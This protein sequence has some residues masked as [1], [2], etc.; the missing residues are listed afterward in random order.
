MVQLQETENQIITVYTRSFE[1]RRGIAN[2]WCRAVESHQQQF[3][4]VPRLVAADAAFYSK[5]NEDKLHEMGVF[6][7]AVPNRNTRSEER[8]RLQ[9]RRW[10][11]E[12]QRWR[13]GY[14]GRISVLKRCHGLEP[15][16]L[17]Q[18]RRN[19]ALG[20]RRRDRRQ[21]YQHRKCAGASVRPPLAQPERRAGYQAG[22]RC[23]S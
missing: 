2:C 13:T 11:N 16:P 4:R 5:V 12:G 3:N 7:V 22:P 10:F 23:M 9:R 19:Q 6:R 8:K 17:S 1:K 18:A 15:L 14:E 21:L 20:R